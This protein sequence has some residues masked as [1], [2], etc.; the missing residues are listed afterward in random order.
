MYIG[1]A[2]LSIPGN[3]FNLNLKQLI[4]DMVNVTV[5][6]GGSEEETQI[7]SGMTHCLDSACFKGTFFNTGVP[8]KR[9]AWGLS[10]RL[11]L[12]FL[13]MLLVGD[14]NPLVFYLSFLELPHSDI[15]PDVEIMP[16]P[17]VADVGDTNG[18]GSDTDLVPDSMNFERVDMTAKVP[19][20]QTVTIN[21]PRFPPTGDG[22]YHYDSV[23][24]LAGVIVRGAGFVPL[25]VGSG[26][27]QR[28]GDDDKNGV[29]EEPVEVAVA[30]VA[31]RLPEGT[32][33]R[34]LLAVALDYAEIENR[35][36]VHAVAGQ[37][38]FLDDFGGTVELDE[39]MPPAVIEY[40][41]VGRTL[42]VASVPPGADYVQAVFHSENDLG[43]W[44]ILDDGWDGTFQVPTE[45]TFWDRSSHATFVAVDLRE[46]VSYQD[47][48]EFNSTN[49]GNLVELVEAFVYVD[50]ANSPN[51]ADCSMGGG[52]G[53]FF[54][55]II[56]GLALLRRA[57]A[58]W[59]VLIAVFFCLAGCGDSDPGCEVEPRF[60]LLGD[61]E[62]EL[63]AMCLSKEFVAPE[64]L[65]A[66]VLDDLA[67]IRS[68]FGGELAVINE[69][70][71]MPPWQESAVVVAFNESTAAEIAAG[72][73]TGWDEL[74]R[75][76]H[77]ID[78]NFTAEVGWA[79]LYFQGLLHPRCLCRRYKGIPGAKD[80]MP[81]FYMGEVSN[82][83][84]RSTGGGITYLF[85][86]GAGDC[87]SGCTEEDYWYFKFDQ[88]QPVLVGE[89]LEGQPEPG[90][91]KEAEKN[92]EAF[93]MWYW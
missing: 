59:L 75:E 15:V 16:I 48:L 21:V 43:S 7:P 83:Y 2:G 60:E 69:I 65:Y 58:S 50:D 14:P 31:G 64:E 47:I 22:G 61:R 18:N 74:N 26:V 17:R 57:S 88:G 23:I 4:G 19:A 28:D 20:D 12:S 34:V 46:G 53:L 42:D 93:Q 32:Y 24:V 91:W 55:W 27:D 78:Y 62:A 67:A 1:I 63:V 52:G 73:Y 92:I 68:A 9:I 35:E 10:V 40:D 11:D 13:S 85:Y 71:F 30:D 36:G 37:V 81:N 84:A 70:T 89:R 5:E 38:R 72:E 51:C 90:W 80:T 39:F 49:M 29:L 6:L 77:L 44:L 25:G 56:L 82:I 87:P 45:S 8:R 76:L 41:A 3:L 66:Q 54:V 79:L 33:R 86:R